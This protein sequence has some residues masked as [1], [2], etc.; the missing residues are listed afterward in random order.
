M[1]IDDVDMDHEDEGAVTEKPG[2]G[3]LFRRK[4]ASARKTV[5]FGDASEV[6]GSPMWSITA[7]ITL[8]AVWYLIKMGEE[9]LVNDRTF[10]SQRQTLD[11]FI[12]RGTK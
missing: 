12:G 2:P 6:S 3:F 1:S 8:M 7:L 9:P 10:P 4:G 11:A 5:T